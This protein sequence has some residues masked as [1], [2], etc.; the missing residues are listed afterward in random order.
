MSRSLRK[1]LLEKVKCHIGGGGGS[2]KCQKS[3]TY[4]L[5]G[6]KERNK[7]KRVFMERERERERQ[8]KRESEREK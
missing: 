3:V 4:Y 6:P 2:E 7:E 5:N 8:R 1:Q